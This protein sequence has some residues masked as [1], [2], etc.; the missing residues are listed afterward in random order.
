M[1]SKRI[2]FLKEKMGVIIGSIKILNGEMNNSFLY[3]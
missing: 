2:N 1:K 3:S